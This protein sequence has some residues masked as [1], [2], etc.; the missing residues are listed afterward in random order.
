MDSKNINGK[1]KID[2]GVLK[3][4]YA[5]FVKF[6]ENNKTE[7]DQA[8]IIQAFE[9]CYE[10]SW[11]IIKRYLHEDGISSNSPRTAFREAWINGYIKDAKQWFKFLDT[12]NI[13]VHTY[14]EVVLREVMKVMPEFKEELGALLNTL[15]NR[16]YLEK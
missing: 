8:G 9:F 11:K 15:E 10:L 2:V 1:D 6:M 13:T 3:K 4:A 7:Q 14:N 16:K 12:R 5:M